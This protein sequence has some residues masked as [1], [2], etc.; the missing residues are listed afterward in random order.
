MSALKI[1]IGMDYND[2]LKNRNVLQ[3]ERTL[4]YF[5][6]FQSDNK[7]YVKWISFID[8]QLIVLRMTFF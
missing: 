4:H 1:G 3:S 8:G 2:N 6:A 7:C 5:S